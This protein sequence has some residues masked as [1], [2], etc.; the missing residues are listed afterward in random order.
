MSDPL[1]AL[2]KAHA[3]AREQRARALTKAL[4]DALVVAEEVQTNCRAALG[5]ELNSVASNQLHLEHAVKQ[6]RAQIAALTRQGGAYARGYVALVRAVSEL[7][8]TGPFLAATEAALART[9]EHLAF[10][11]GRL[12]S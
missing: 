6:L 10:V 4:G 5:L 9:N 8:P 1:A 7:P 12:E 2:L 11:A 3:A